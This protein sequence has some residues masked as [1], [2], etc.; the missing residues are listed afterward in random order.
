[1]GRFQPRIE[2]QGAL[3]G[4]LA[5]DPGHWLLQLHGPG[6]IGKTTLL[7]W[8]VSRACVTADRTVPA[9][10]INCDDFDV[11]TILSQPWLLLIEAAQQL[12]GQLPQAPFLQLIR[13]YRDRSIAAAVTSDPRSIEHIG[14]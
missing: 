13:D 8:F 9:A 12:N 10:I 4:L 7:R 14:R 1:D 2:V 5:P 11:L 3:A 6:G